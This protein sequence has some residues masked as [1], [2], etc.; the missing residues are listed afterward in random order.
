MLSI[1]FLWI[2]DVLQVVSGYYL[3]IDLK[4]MGLYVELV[5]REVLIHGISTMLN[6]SLVSIF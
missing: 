1:F 2:E 5:W 4:I 3:V 6:T